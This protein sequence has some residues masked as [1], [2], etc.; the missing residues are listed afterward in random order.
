MLRWAQQLPPA[1]LARLEQIG[2][3]AAQLRQPAYLVGGPVRDALLGRPS[4]D[5]DVTVEGDVSAL[6][7]A[8]AEAFGGRVVLHERFGT[9][10]VE[11]AEGHIDLTS[12]R[13]E[14]YPQPGALPEVAPASIEEDLRRRDF[15]YNAMA[16]RL[17]PELGALYDP[18]N[19]FADLRAGVT[20]G[21][22]PKT[23]QEDPTRIL[24]AA[25]YSARL[26]CRLEENTKQW[27]LTAIQDGAF[28]TVTG[29]RIWGELARLL[30]ETTFAEALW[31]LEEWGALSALG[32]TSAPHLCLRRLYVAQRLLGFTAKERAWATLG[33][34]AGTKTPCFAAYF[35]LARAEAEGALSAAEAVA[36]KIKGE[37]LPTAIFARDVKNSTLYAIFSSLPGAALI[38]L[39]AYFSALRPAV[40]R[41]CQL[42]PALDI[43]GDDLQAAGF[44][45]SPGFKIALEAARRAKLDEQA[46][47]TRQLAVAQAA[48]KQWLQT[49]PCESD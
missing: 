32:F 14:I 31:K 28:R 41:F 40:E 37:T 22:H 16:L 20:R 25:R 18:W 34:L 33:I 42:E 2:R 4:L 1:Y 49:H 24:R 45:P 13:R 11:L 3:L 39:W 19:G 29:Q 12:A 7:A 26:G 21:L 5:I 15:T 6:A 35:G 10:V 38:T 9:A 48:L 30:E 23:F 36:G 43:N 47:R 27:L 46:D 17:D 8:L 44:A